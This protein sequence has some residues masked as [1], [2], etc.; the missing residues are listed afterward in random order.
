M[1]DRYTIRRQVEALA[2]ALG[3]AEMND[4]RMAP[5]F[6]ELAKYD[7]FQVIAAIEK[8]KQTSTTKMPTPLRIAKECGAIR[9]HT[10][11]QKVTLVDIL[12]NKYQATLTGNNRVKYCPVCR[13]VMANNNCS[14]CDAGLPLEGSV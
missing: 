10:A 4:V 1:A 8:I 14:L 5:Y 7:N 2:S 11:S 9:T 3:I 6:K 13:R 12:G